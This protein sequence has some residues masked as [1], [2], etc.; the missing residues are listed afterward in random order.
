LKGTL[1]EDLVWVK[2]ELIDIRT[3]LNRVK[4]KV[5]VE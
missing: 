1:A 2:D 5:G 4:Q 3:T